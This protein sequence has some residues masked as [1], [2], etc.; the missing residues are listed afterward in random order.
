MGKHIFVLPSEKAGSAGSLA[1][2][3]GGSEGEAGGADRL[4]GGATVALALDSNNSL[5]YL[6]LSWNKV[7]E[8]GSS[9]QASPKICFCFEWATF[10]GL[11]FSFGGNMLSVIGHGRRR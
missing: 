1:A 6:D 7:G 5:T 2:G 3:V 8:S 10:Q 9:H 11:I 4:T